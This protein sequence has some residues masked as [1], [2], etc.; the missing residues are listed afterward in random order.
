LGK[1]ML[2]VLKEDLQNFDRRSLLTLYLLIKGILYPYDGDQT[3]LGDE[4]RERKFAATLVCPHCASTDVIR[5]GHFKGRQRWRCKSCLKTFSDYTLS[6]LFKTRY[7]DK[8]IE[9][10]WYM[11]QGKCLRAT[12]KELEI[13]LPTAF[14]WRHKILK[15]LQKLDLAPFD[16]IVELDETFFLY[17]EKGNKKIAG[18]AARKRGGTASRRGISREQ[19]CVLVAYGRDSERSLSKVVGT[20]KIRKTAI[21]RTMSPL[22]TPTTIFCTDADRA[23]RPYCLEKGIHH[24]RLRPGQRKNGIYHVQHVN[25]YHSRLKDWVRRFNGVASKY[26]DHYLAWFEFEREKRMVSINQKTKDMLITACT[27]GVDATWDS[28]RLSR[29][30]MPR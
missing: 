12:A 1:N 11:F 21:D 30:N 18:R 2:E 4:I 9:Y 17:S 19:V 6:P 24:I 8:W 25:S 15:A 27:K 10:V 26:L 14:F 13:A 22:V 16:G 29:F 5:F 20:G 3:N 23:Y 28:I 7:P